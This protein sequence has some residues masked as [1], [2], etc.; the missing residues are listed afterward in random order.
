MRPIVLIFCVVVLCVQTASAGPAR[1]EVYKTGALTPVTDVHSIILEAPLIISIGSNTWRSPAGERGLLPGRYV[2]TYEDA[3]GIFFYGPGRCF[4]RGSVAQAKYYLSQGGFWIPKRGIGTPKLFLVVDSNLVIAK[5]ISEAAAENAAG[6]A[7]Q[8]GVQAG[9]SPDNLSRVPQ[10]G[11]GGTIAG[12]IISSHNG[13]IVLF[14]TIDDESAIEM[15]K[16]RVDSTDKQT[17]TPAPVH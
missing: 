2:S 14:P 1:P 9:S 3:K 4:F 16:A 15:L 12:A 11:L 10:S 17:L 5:S 7:E 8:E 13:E 6:H